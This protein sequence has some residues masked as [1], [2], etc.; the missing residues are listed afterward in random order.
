MDYTELMFALKLQK[1]DGVFSFEEFVTPDPAQVAD[2]IKAG[3]EYLKKCRAEAKDSL[4]EPF[5]TFNR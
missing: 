1:W 5:V 4:E 2:E 3:I